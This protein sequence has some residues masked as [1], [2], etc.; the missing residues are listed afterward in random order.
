MLDLGHVRTF[1]AVAEELHFRRAALRLNMTQSPLSRQVQM[2]EQELGV[3]LFTRANRSIRLTPAGR[4]FLVEATALLQQA[5]AAAQAVRQAVRGQ[6]GSVAVGFIGACSYGFLPRLVA[7]TRRELPDITLHFHEMTTSQQIEA[8]IRG[9]LHLCLARPGPL[10]RELQ[11]SCVQHEG[12]AL[13]LPIDH[14]LARLRRPRLAQLDG[15][16]FIMYSAEGSYMRD[17]LNAWFRAARVQPHI[18][19]QMSHAHAILSLVST[20]LG[21]A[22]VPEEARNACFDNVVFRPVAPSGSQG[23][24]LHAIWR[25]AG[26]NDALPP[27]RDLMLRQFT[28]APR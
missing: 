20:G 1:V 5:E 26:D 17:M 28:P 6:P 13:A 18:V 19:Q 8:L 3:A 25:I 16:A 14:P 21:L 4:V 10:P 15:E 9:Q 12:L 7:A 22:I 27:V 11:S 2:L 23:A 24:E